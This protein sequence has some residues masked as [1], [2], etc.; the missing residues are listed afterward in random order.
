MSGSG[1]TR[2]VCWVKRRN[3]MAARAKAQGKNRA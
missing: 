3:L 2:A 1:D